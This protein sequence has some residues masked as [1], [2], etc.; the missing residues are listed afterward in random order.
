MNTPMSPRF[1]RI[2]KGRLKDSGSRG[3]PVNRQQSREM[4]KQIEG[5]RKGCRR[6][7]AV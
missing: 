5:E 6:T 2:T 7:A 1:V 3:Q 4:L